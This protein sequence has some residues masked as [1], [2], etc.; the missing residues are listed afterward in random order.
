MSAPFGI[1]I[2]IP[3]CLQRC[4]YCDFATYVHSEIKP[5]EFY[6]EQVKKEIANRKTFFPARRLDT[7]YFGGGTPSLIPAELIVD[8]ISE[9]AKFGYTTGPETEVTIEI[10]PATVDERKLQTYLAAGVNRFSVGAQSFSDRL[11]KMVNREH[12]SRQTIETLELLRKYNLNFS[13]DLLFALPTQTVAELQNDVSIALQLGSSHISPYCLTV[14]ESHPL[15]KNRPLDSEQIDMFEIIHNELTKNSFVQYE[16]SNYAL[17][18]F[19]S[20]HNMLYWTDVEYWGLGLSAHSYSKQ[21]PW[22]SR[23]WNQNSFE[24]YTSQIQREGELA[25]LQG[26]YGGQIETLQKHQSLTDFCY[27][28]LR[29]N[30][31]LSVEKLVRKFGEPCLKMVTKIAEPIVQRGLMQHE[32]GHFR[33]TGPG[34]LVSNQIFE[35]FAFLEGE[36]P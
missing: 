31:G 18:G 7:L 24:L 28:S 27:T 35:K 30:Q 9:L 3:Y 13:F 16:L 11:L 22:G 15:S 6:V 32:N 4:T 23:F 33:L 14:P 8:L 26:F 2:H 21:S 5:P 17:P 10:N 25:S 1:Y 12:N 34:L 20:K 36:L 19:E 29:L